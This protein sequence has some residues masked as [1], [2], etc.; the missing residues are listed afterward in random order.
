MQL[1]RDFS[2][3]HLSASVVTIG[4]F[5]GLHIGHQR[6][7]NQTITQA[8]QLEVPSVLLTFE[9]LPFAYFN[10]TALHQIMPLRT[11]YDAL[12]AFSLDYVGL[13]RF[14][15]AISNMSSQTFIE[16]CLVKALGAKVLVVGKDFCFG[17]A[18]EGNVQ[19]LQKMGEVHGYQVIVLPD[20]C[21]AE[22]K[23]S[24]SK[25]RQ[26]LI[27]GDMSRARALLGRPF[28]LVAR[29]QTGKKLG[30]TLGFP[31]ANLKIDPKFMLLNG[32][33]ICWALLGKQRYPAVCNVGY[34]PTVNSFRKKI[35]VH[36]LD[37]Q[38][39][40]YGQLLRVEFLEKI[41]NEKKFND[42]SELIANIKHDIMV[43]RQYFSKYSFTT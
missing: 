9:P 19:T 25:V 1:F 17:R 28:H 7:I 27:A 26:A 23:I 13:L 16:A 42:L 3:I 31:T 38:G 43:A 8:K 14:N 6:L 32:V 29:V 40:L 37:F 39:D 12:S 5:D 20:E 36:I 33:Y 11:K 22:E 15:A 4:N 2:S 35:E 10:P 41:R 30:R 24:S 21:L 34:Q 18:R